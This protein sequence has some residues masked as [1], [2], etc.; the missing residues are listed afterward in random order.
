MAFPQTSIQMSRVFP[1]VSFR[2][3]Y[4]DAS[5]NL[6]IGYLLEASKP[7]Y[8]QTCLLY[9]HPY[10]SP[11]L[12]PFAIRL[13]WYEPLY[14]DMSRSPEA[15]LHTPT[16]YQTDLSSEA[17]DAGI[18][19]TDMARVWMSDGLWLDQYYVIATRSQD[20][21]RDQASKRHRLGAHIFSALVIDGSYYRSMELFCPYV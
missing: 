21:E 15:Y 14:T 5:K 3:C 17:H 13:H 12:S 8:I 9:P 20:L 1:S 2:E 6:L 16:A 7:V 10:S 18:H 4:L 11:Y 19:A